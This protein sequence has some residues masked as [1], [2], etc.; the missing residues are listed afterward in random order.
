M[1]RSKLFTLGGKKVLIIFIAQAILDYTMSYFALPQTF[2][3][4]LI[5]CELGSGGVRVG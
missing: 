5:R 3:M 1:E 2:M 4:I